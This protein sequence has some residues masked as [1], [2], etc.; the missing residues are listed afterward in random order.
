MC[1]RRD[2]NAIHTQFLLPGAAGD[3]C[4]TDCNDGCVPIELGMVT[5]ILQSCQDFEILV[6]AMGYLFGLGVTGK[7]FQVEGFSLQ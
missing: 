5:D 6:E 3:C 1:K 2:G 7:I 4:Y